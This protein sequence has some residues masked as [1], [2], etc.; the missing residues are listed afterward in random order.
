MTSTKNTYISSV[1]SYDR[2]EVL[3]FERSDLGRKTVRYPA[4]YFFYVEDDNGKYKDIYGKPLKKLSFPDKDSFDQARKFYQSSG[5]KLWESD[6][7]PES[8]VLSQHYYGAPVGALNVLFFDIEID[9]DKTRGFDGFNDPYA[10]VSAIS[11]YDTKKKKMFLDVIPPKGYSGDLTTLPDD[12]TEDCEVTIL[13]TESEILERFLNHI[14]DIDIISGW[15]SEGFDVPYMYERI[16]LVLGEKASKR[17]SFEGCR[18]PYYKEVNDKN[19]LP[20]RVLVISGRVHLDFMNLFFKFDPGGRDSFALDAVAEDVLKIKKIEYDG[21]LADLY[22]ND[23]MTFIKYNARDSVLLKKLE[24]ARGYIKLA[25]LLSHMDTGQIADVNGTV[26]LTE[27]AIINYCHHELNR[28]VPDVNM[29]FDPNMGKFAGAFVLPP[30][31]GLHEW[32]ASIDVKSL[33]PSAMRTVNISPDTLVGQFVEN[34]RAFLKIQMES[35]EGITF[36]TESQQFITKTAKEW[37]KYFNEKKYALSGYGTVFDQNK[38]G[39][40]PALLADWYAQRKKY[41]KMSKAALARATGA[42]CEKERNEA[43]AEYEYFDKVQLVFKLKLNSTYGACGNKYFRFFDIRLA[44]STTKTGREILFHMARSIGEVVDGE[45]VYPNSS[46]IYGDTDSC[47]FETMAS[48]FDSA[49][50]IAD[51]IE[52]YINKSFDKFATEKFFATKD[53]L[54]IFGVSQEI[55]ANRGIFIDGKKSYMLRV[56]LKDGKEVDEIKITG[57]AIKKTTL[58]KRVREILIEGLSDFLRGKDWEDVGMFYLENKENLRTWDVFQ[59]GLPKKVKNFETYSS[60]FDTDPNSRTP[61]HVK[62]AILWNKC[63]SMYGD[64]ESFKIVS[65]MRIKVLYFK[66]PING[67]NSIAVPVDLNKKPEWF[68]IHMED[69]ICKITQASKLLEAPMKS[70]LLAINR[71]I[72]TRQKLLINE[73]FEF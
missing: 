21:S 47:Y 39:I 28:I 43:T 73:A 41:Q 1:L 19:G 50:K 61:G 37:K 59:L 52:S 22:A 34:E 17:L 12:V 6:I 23:F 49:K 10:P 9:Y 18:T 69:K 56:L 25:I 3:V 42:T 27:S 38:I 26:K 66:K 32:V 54:G 70:I 11:Y 48:D 63:L 53:F 13:K 16:K 40:I 33:Y 35:E 64:M 57:L 14:S 36:K 71:E 2:T 72:P 15:N 30:R 4:E 58:P 7:S 29:E 45:Y 5:N 60:N 31:P 24:E 67:F 46:V 44:E 20:T 68:K 51:F 62:A 8:R 65:G 55:I